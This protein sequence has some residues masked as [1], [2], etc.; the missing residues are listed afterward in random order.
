[1][2]RA[3]AWVIIYGRPGRRESGIPGYGFW[4][5][6]SFFE[7]REARTPAATVK[8]MWSQPIKVK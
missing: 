4:N 8:I 1:M 5:Q 3:P 6:A 2:Q 7:A